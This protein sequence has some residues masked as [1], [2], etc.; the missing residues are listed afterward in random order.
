MTSARD[1]EPDQQP[2]NLSTRAGASSPYATG[3]GGVTLERRVAALYLGRLLTGE[4]APELGSDRRVVG[5]SFQQ[6]MK[7]PIDDIVVHAARPDDREPSLQLAIAVRRRPKVVSSDPDMQ[8]LVADLV[9]ACWQTA[10]DDRREHRLA[11]AVGGL[12]THAGQLAELTVHARHQRDEME[13]FALV[14]EPRRFR[15]GLRDRLR[16]VEALV[17][18]AIG[19]QEMIEESD[20]GFAR[21]CAWQLLRSLHVLQVRVEEPDTNDWADAQNRLTRVARDGDVAAAGRLLDRLESL[22]GQY[23]PSAATVDA[24]LLRRAVHKLLEAGV[25]RSHRGWDVLGRLDGSAQKAVRDHVGAPGGSETWQLDRGPQ[26]DDLLAK[27]DEAGAVLV[28]GESGIGKSALALSA[29]E[30]VRSIGRVG[31]LAEATCLNLRDLPGT[32]LELE[33][34]LGAPLGDLLAQMSAP[35]RYV[36]LDA[37]D[38]AAES[39]RDMLK[40]IVDAAIS[41]D[42]RL[43]AAVS[44]DGRPIVAEILT[45]RLGDNVEHYEVAPLD[46]AALASLVAAFPRLERL[47]Q[48]PRSR[49]LLRRLVVVDLLVRSNITEAPLSA[50]EAMRAIWAGLIRRKEQRDRGLP[51]ARDQAMLRLAAHELTGEAL[52]ALDAAALDG[53]RRDG[54]L[55]PGQDPWQLV[56]QFAHDE[57]RRYAVARLLLAQEDVAAVL[58]RAGAPRWALGAATLAAQL[59]L[60]RP[61]PP[62][63]IPSGRLRALQSSFDAIVEAGHG[64]RWADVPNEALLTLGDPSALADAWPALLAGDAAGLRACS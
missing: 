9:A 7:S 37:A 44:D 45:D 46:D 35:R 40:Y 32:W 55:R 20:T 62:G 26:A 21:R 38:A 59:E 47:A 39:G 22:A 28:G 5:V 63:S 36:V 14:E 51:D 2:Y 42:V 19:E 1:D 48:S 53:L 60:A 23:A 34:A 30:R 16:H 31:E 43:I 8:R 52:V 56:P 3:G 24:S 64:D 17:E 6:E 49:E 10:G 33:Q 18:R 54:L 61:A 41:G 58:M 27:A 12:Q 15:K 13:F 25:T 57:L 50:A 4:I 29:A 11:I